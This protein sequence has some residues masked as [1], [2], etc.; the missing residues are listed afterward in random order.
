MTPQ[1]T[2]TFGADSEGNP[3]A[4]LSGV[5]PEVY[6]GQDLEAL[7]RTVKQIRIDLDSGITGMRHY[8]ETDQ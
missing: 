2:A 5:P 3:I 4:V 6:A 1:L 7:A 8:P